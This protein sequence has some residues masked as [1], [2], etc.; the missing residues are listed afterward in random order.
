MTAYISDK[1]PEKND[2]NHLCPMTVAVVNDNG[3][4]SDMHLIF[5]K[6]NLREDCLGLTS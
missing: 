6:Q 2:H 3:Q 1:F 4:E 5:Q